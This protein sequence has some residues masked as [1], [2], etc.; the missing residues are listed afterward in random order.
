MDS[1]LWKIAVVGA[2]VLTRVFV[3]TLTLSTTEKP[4]ASDDHARGLLEVLDAT[5]VAFGWVFF[6]IQPFFLQ[7][8]YIP[9]GSMENTLQWRPTGDRLLVSKWIYRV[10]GPQ[11]GDVVVFV[12]PCKARARQGDEYIKRCIGEP[13]DVISVQN[14]RYFRRARGSRK[15]VALREPYVKWSA[16]LPLYGYDLKIVGG[17]IFSREY[18]SANAPGFWQREGAIGRD[19]PP[20]ENQGAIEVASS[21]PIPADKYLVL[22]DHRNDSNDSHVWGLVP[23]SAF[24]GKAMCVFWPPSRVG[25]LDKMSGQPRALPHSDALSRALSSAR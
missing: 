2:I 17:K 11:F 13:G 25:T 4:S 8:F 18:A 20:F 24:I 12:P 7:A 15:T 22:G 1:W 6:V 5:A 21:E 19:E 23:R 10:R 9:S 14:R 3:R 16:G